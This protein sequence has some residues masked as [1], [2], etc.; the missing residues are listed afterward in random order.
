MFLA[1]FPLC[2]RGRRFSCRFS[3]KI[4]SPLHVPHCFTP[5]LPLPVTQDLDASSSCR[6]HP[7]HSTE[8][9]LGSPGWCHVAVEITSP[10][11]PV[12]P[13]GDGPSHC[14][15][16][17]CTARRALAAAPVHL[18]LVMTADTDTVLAAARSSSQHKAGQSLEWQHTW[19]LQPQQ[20]PTACT[21]CSG[22]MA[23]MVCPLL[24]FQAS[25]W[26]EPWGQKGICHLFSLGRSGHRHDPLP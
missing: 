14:S 4:L 9:S 5:F 3:S 17:C 12:Q 26:E 24:A 11:R 2:V 10:S 15:T 23:A 20:H 13:H 22:Q 19:E 21:A 16:D 6:R 1:S 8:L 7:A 18:S 25:C